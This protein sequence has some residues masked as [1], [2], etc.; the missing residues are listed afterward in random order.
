M[1][2]KFILQGLV[3]FL[4]WWLS[5]F[6]LLVKTE[7]TAPMEK[8]EK[9]ALYLVIQSFVGRSWNGS[10]LYP[11]PCGW[12]P[13]QGVSCDIFNG[14]W[15]ITTLNI[16]PVLD[17]SLQCAPDAKFTPT[18][19]NLTHLKS[20]SFYNCFSLYQNPE[21]IPDSNWDKFASL[22]TLEFRSNTG[23]T[24]PVPAG[25]GLVKSL[26]SLVLVGNGLTGQIPLEI[27]NLVNLR[28]LVISG[29]G[30]TGSIPSS[31]GVLNSL[32]K[33]DLSHNVL[34]GPLPTVLGNLKT[35]TLMD[36]RNNSFTGG[37]TKSI[38][39]MI[40]LQDLLLSNNPLLRGTLV[41]IDWSGLV[42]LTTLDLSNTGLTGSIP[43]SLT[44]LKTVRCLALDTNNLT[45]KVPSNLA[46][47]P[48]LSALYING[49]N[50]SGK[51][52]FSQGFYEKM[53]RR[54]SSWNNPNLCFGPME[55]NGPT[56]VQE[57]TGQKGDN[58]GLRNKVDRTGPY[59]N[60]SLSVSLGLPGYRV[61]G[62]WWVVL[63]QELMAVLI[64]V[65]VF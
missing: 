16:G 41:Q 47:M 3:I 35:L 17:N 2:N 49:N 18:L 30:L 29:N 15:Y 25:L 4:L 14:L 52:E 38:Q 43:D 33:L 63:V 60:S 44:G 54:F 12:T 57:C 58:I 21:K 48:N 51:L 56:G 34:S 40:S 37:L 53:G 19:F 36:L 10:D 39:N 59:V 65:I 27:G 7:E 64:L 8:T 28:R 62:F 11:D 45:G 26:K 13:I 61:G 50:F 5:S 55:I 46:S 22:E 9:D 24:G 1:E 32:L 23:L 20:L 31:I 42:N 6:A